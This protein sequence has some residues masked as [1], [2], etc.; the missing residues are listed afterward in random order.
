MT[1]DWHSYFSDEC[2]KFIAPRMDGIIGA[3]SL[4][5]ATVLLIA[6][7]RGK[8]W[9]LSLLLVVGFADLGY[10]G[11]RTIYGTHDIHVHTFVDLE[12]YRKSQIVPPAQP[13]GRLQISEIHGNGAMI[14]GW[15]LTSGYVGLSPS[16]SLDY[17][18]GAVL[19][20]AGTTWRYADEQWHAVDGL[21]RLR[22]YDSASHEAGDIAVTKDRPGHVEVRVCTNA[23]KKLDFIESYHPNWRATIDGRPVEVVRAEGDFQGCVVPAGEHD[24][25]FHFDPVYRTWGRW[26]SLAGLC[27]TLATALWMARGRESTMNPIPS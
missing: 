22:W 17:H 7:G 23:T 24:V 11:F 19:R 25:E 21:P 16:R 12:T 9:A 2:Q 4:T 14:L 13:P 15:S 18:T 26:L 1:I 8:S 5:L 6:A 20:T 10:W 3:M 27:L